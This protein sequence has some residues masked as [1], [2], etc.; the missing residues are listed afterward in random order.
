MKR[1]GASRIDDG[2]A[3]LDAY[4][5]PGIQA[6]ERP[7]GGAVSLRMHARRG[8]RT[9]EGAGSGFLLTADGYLLTNRRVAEAGAGIVVTLDDG[10][11]R[12]AVHVGGDIDTDL[13]L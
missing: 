7:R 10:S 5:R 4:S 2:L 13:A 9:I 12:A 8:L 1:D 11:E 3:L 6:L